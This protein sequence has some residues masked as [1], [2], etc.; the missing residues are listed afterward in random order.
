MAF[1]AFH[2]S[3][4]PAPQATPDGAML[5]AIGDV[6]GHLKHLKALLGV[7]QPEIA[8]A[9]ERGLACELIMIGDYVD[10]GPASLGVL[11]E[12]DGLDERLGIPVHLLRG[13]H[14][15]YMIDFLTAEQQDPEALEAW[16][17][18]GGSSTLAELG[19]GMKELLDH[20]PLDLAAKARA[21]AGADLMAVLGR[22]ELYRSIGGYV[23][24]HGGIQ[25]GVPLG[26]QGLRELLWLREPFLTGANWSHPFTAVHGHTI[27]GPEVLPHRI[28][29]DSGVYRTGVL[30]A[31]Q[32]A[33]T[34][35][36]FHSVGSNGRSKAFDRLPGLAQKRRFSEPRRLPANK[37]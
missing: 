30:T 34:E 6:H 31:V 29:I 19:I 17:G 27:R 35:L 12:L 24:V 28:A 11:R 15:H 8:A 22:L 3:W 20:D 1:H 23:F 14:D 16:C 33:G 13:N 7:L 32:L 37:G 36:R 26:A 9:R 4:E 25:P 5:F 21:A 10:R 18:N 2:S